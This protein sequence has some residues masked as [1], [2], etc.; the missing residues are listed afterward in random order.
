MGW[1]AFL[2]IIQNSKEIIKTELLDKLG[3]QNLIQLEDEPFE[4]AMNPDDNHVYIGHY[5]NNLIICAPDIPMDFFEK[6][7][8]QTERILNEIFPDSEI[9]AII[10]QSTVNLWG[11]SITKHGRKIRARAGSADDG[12]FLEVGDPLEE[13]LDLLS[14]STKGENG[15]RRYILEGFP[16]EQFLEDQVGENFVFSICSR[17]FGEQLDSADSLLYDTMFT[18]Y[19]YSKPRKATPVKREEKVVSIRQKPWWKFW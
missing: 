6:S 5:R 15:Q 2:I 17:Y 3:F 12:T 1:K 16:D 7:E 8:R 18:A 11:Y 14:K 19:K 9:C 4:M 10:L 13:E